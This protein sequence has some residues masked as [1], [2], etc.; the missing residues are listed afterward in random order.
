MLHW[1]ASAHSRVVPAAAFAYLAD[2]RRAPEWFA[3]VDV[4]DVAPGPPHAG[5]TWRFVEHR[6]GGAPSATPVRM[7]VYDPPRRFIWETQLTRG[8]TNV[9]WEL[10]CEPAAE[11][12][13]TLR[14]TLRWRPGPL[15]WPMALAAAVF[16]R[17][18][19]EERTQR[20]VE[21]ARD[22]V[23]AAHPPPAGGRRRRQ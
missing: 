13:T 15:G 4:E 22:A 2:P 12:G 7:A 5:Q 19:L 1:A 14:L 11:G 10:A 9:A 16:M 18:A 17:G 3:R 23:E 21:R 8:R 6:R 20:T